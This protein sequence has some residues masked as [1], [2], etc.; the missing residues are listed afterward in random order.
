MF[1]IFI[2][3]YHTCKL[4]SQFYWVGI[5]RASITKRAA[6]SQFS[7]A[8]S[9]ESH[10]PGFRRRQGESFQKKQHRVSLTLDA[11]CVD[12]IEDF[13]LARSEVIVVMGL[14]CICSADHTISFL[15]EL[16]NYFHYWQVKFR[17][18]V[19]APQGVLVKWYGYSSNL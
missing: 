5:G 9:S 15:L 10:S 4:P 13:L 7:E 14:F 2:I 11:R 19:P 1:Y 6:A 8:S 17:L 12:R 3:T 16:L 18:E